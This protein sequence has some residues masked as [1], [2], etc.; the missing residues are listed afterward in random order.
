MNFGISTSSL[1]FNSTLAFFFL[2]SA[3]GICLF[4]SLLLDGL[5]GSFA[6][7]VRHTG[8]SAGFRSIEPVKSD[9]LRRPRTTLISTALLAL[10][11]WL[12]VPIQFVFLVLFLIQLYSA[13]MAQI[14]AQEKEE[15]WRTNRV[16]QQ[17]LLLN[18]YFWLLPF[19][20]PAL[21][22]WTRNLTRGY[23][24]ALGGPDHNILYISG[25]IAI[26]MISSSGVTIQRCQS[27]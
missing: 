5:I 2:T 22:I 1:L 4:A 15:N 16:N 23:F 7:I 19:N 14:S 12:A 3:Y 26:T 11:I 9:I 21:L 24:G 13:V 20:A 25:F 27:R 8:I 18:V 17:K 10:M 6:T